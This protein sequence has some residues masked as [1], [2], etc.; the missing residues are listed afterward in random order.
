MIFNA[1]TLLGFENAYEELNTEGELGDNLAENLATLNNFT[2]QEQKLLASNLVLNCPESQLRDLNATIQALY[3]PIPKGNSNSFYE[4][5][6][7]HLQVRQKI[8]ALF[9]KQNKHAA[10][11]FCEEQDLLNF[12]S[13]FALECLKGKEIALATQ[14][15]LKTEDRTVRSQIISNV[16]RIFPDS[17]FSQKLSNA[18]I[19][20]REM[21]D[22]LF[23]ETPHNFF[24]SPEFNADNYLEFPQLL[25]LIKKDPAIPARLIN[26]PEVKKARVLEGIEQLYPNSLFLESTRQSFS[27]PQKLLAP[28]SA[29]TFNTRSKLEEDNNNV[30]EYQA[31]L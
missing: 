31:T 29:G 2:A 27:I 20:L 25:E 6:N 9:D 26:T 23:S 19:L 24:L 30:D 16:C 3:Q 10:R 12:C 5:L 11:L 22:K 17:E 4:V 18:F 28:Q 13:E 14:L 15:A 8:L 21:E 1:K 7:S